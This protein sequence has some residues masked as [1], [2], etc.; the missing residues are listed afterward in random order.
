VLVR[1]FGFDLEVM[2]LV[3]AYA[4]EEIGVVLGGF[5]FGLAGI[6]R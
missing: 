4:V 5:D 3:A 1:E 6:F 2:R